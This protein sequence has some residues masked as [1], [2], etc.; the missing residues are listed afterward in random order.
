MK[1]I[2]NRLQKKKKKRLQ[3]STIQLTVLVGYLGELRWIYKQTVF[4]EQHS[5]LGR[6]LTMTPLGQ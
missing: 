2:K 1:S 5:F 3:Y 4:T 6:G